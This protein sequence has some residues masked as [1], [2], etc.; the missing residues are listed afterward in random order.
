MDHIRRQ[1][2]PF[3]QTRPLLPWCGS[4]MEKALTAQQLHLH[5]PGPCKNPANTTN[6]KSPHPIPRKRLDLGHSAL[7]GC[8]LQA[9]AAVAGGVVAHNCAGLN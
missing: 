6:R 1:A 5:S 4:D 3:R 9:A 2:N 7:L 8:L